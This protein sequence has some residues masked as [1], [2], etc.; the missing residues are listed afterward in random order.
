M[1]SVSKSQFDAKTQA[2]NQ[3]QLFPFLNS[4]YNSFHACDFLISFFAFFNAA[5]KLFPGF[6]PSTFLQE[7]KTVP[8][9]TQKERND[10]FKIIKC[11][12]F[13]FTE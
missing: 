12:P 8:I 3:R 1:Q 5:R 4:N 11:F 2:E 9:I 6:L 7:R 10:N 13:K